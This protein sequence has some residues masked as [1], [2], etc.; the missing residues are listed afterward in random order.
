[1]HYRVTHVTDQISDCPDLSFWKLAM[2]WI[3]PKSWGIFDAFGPPLRGLCAIF[4]LMLR[5]ERKTEN[6]KVFEVLV[7]LLRDFDCPGSVIVK[8][9]LYS[10]STQNVDMLS[11]HMLIASKSIWPKPVIHATRL[12]TRE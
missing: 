9:N 5:A 1:M 8:S 4:L 3:K 2:C 6:A 10:L 12:C 11:P 7:Y